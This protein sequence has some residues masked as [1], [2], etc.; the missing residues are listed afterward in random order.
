[1]P[2]RNTYRLTWVS[3][4]LDVGCLFTGAPA[5]RSFCS[6]PWTRGVSL[7]AAPLDLERGVALLSPPLPAQL[8]LLGRGDS[9]QH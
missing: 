2:S 3:L 9:I 7:L 4:T 6:L 8:L 5:K 1:M